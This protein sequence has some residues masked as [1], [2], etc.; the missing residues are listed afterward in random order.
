MSIQ[1]ANKRLN[2]MLLPSNKQSPKTIS[3]IEK[4]VF[5]L[6]FI[7]RKNKIHGGELL[8][9]FE[10]FPDNNKTDGMNH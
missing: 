10:K 6:L 5:F 9:W 7:K 2:I 4:I 3:L 1:N 8:L